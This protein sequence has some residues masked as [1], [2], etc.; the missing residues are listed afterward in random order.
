MFRLLQYKD[1]AKKDKDYK[2]TTNLQRAIEKC[3]IE[4]ANDPTNADLHIKLGD[5]YIAWHL[6]IHQ[7]RQ[8]IDEAITEY[9]R[10]LE[11]YIDSDSIYFKIGM[12]F[13]YKNEIDKAI[14]YFNLAVEKN[15]KNANAYYLLACCH[16]RKAH[17]PDAMDFTQKAIEAK[18]LASSRA[19]Y[20]RYNLYRVMSV[21][22]FKVTLLRQKEFLL[23]LLTLPFDKFAIRS[24]IKMISYLQFMPMLMQGWLLV[25]RNNINEAVDLYKEA[26]EKAPGFILLYCLLGDIYRAMGRYEDAILEYKMAIIVDS[27]NITAYRSLCAVY[28]ELG[29]LDSAVES[30]LKLIEIQPNAA[31][32]YSNLA[33][34]LY[35]KGETKAAISYYQNAITLNPR[36]EWTSIIAQ[37][38][39][40]VFQ[41]AEK[42]TDAAISA[43]HSAYLLTPTDIDIFINLGSAF[44]DKQEYNNALTVYRRAL[45]IDPTNAKIHCNLGFLHWGKGDIDEAIKEYE[46]SIKYDPTYD[47]AYNN[48]GVIYLD[49]LGRVQHAIELFEKAIKFNP[50]YALAHYNLGR[51]VAIKG[52]KV[53]AA[54]LYQVAMDLNNVT[55]ELD[56]QEIQDKIQGLFDS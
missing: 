24:V 47:I 20:L 30:Y 7:A 41:E 45:E 33:N 35:L 36:P 14:N 29:D 40:Y 55:N 4:L 28:E 56:P 5:L 27:L 51:S 1:R 44:Y 38:L 46:L 3:Q 31:E 48:L 54:K 9:Q 37:T 17:F 49:D 22:N 6:D 50:N 2:S 8:Y 12:A 26:L 11:S 53:E 32:F 15:P 39:G 16:T 42:N 43:Y 25:A 34:I 13:Y 10:A 52:D 23:S 18:P 21:K 19:H